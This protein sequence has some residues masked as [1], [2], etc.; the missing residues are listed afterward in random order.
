M[1]SDSA[2]L[3]VLALVLFAFTV[4]AMP[5]MLCRAVDRGPNG[6]VWAIRVTWGSL[7]WLSAT[8]LF[9]WSG[10]PARFQVMPPP[11]MIFL[12]VCLVLTAVLAFSSLGT[13]L[14]SVV[15][16]S[17]LV[18]FQAFRIP[19]E[20][21]L[22]LLFLSGRVP[23]QMTFEGRNL[24]ILS[25]IGALILF[26]VFRGRS[27]PRSLL[28]LWNIAGLALLINIVTVAVLSTP[29]PFRVFH[30]EPANTIVTRF[31][32]IWLPA[33]LV[34]AALFG[35]LLVFRRLLSGEKTLAEART[36]S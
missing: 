20:V 2:S 24:D 28:W 30:N 22:W 13:H 19:V 17:G 4:G 29:L 10:L 32:F 6:R 3:F 21:V 9:A 25:G 15:G 12:A 11:L 14:L 36:T 16:D 23:L 1:F 7:I 18:G 27:I 26:L 5:F 35:H 31:P 8:G 33:V 34:Q